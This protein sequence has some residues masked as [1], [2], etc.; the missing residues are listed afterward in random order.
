MVSTNR[1]GKSWYAVRAGEGIEL[2]E[3]GVFR[4][5]EE[6]RS[7]CLQDFRLLL[8]DEIRDLANGRLVFADIE[9]PLRVR[10]AFECATILGL[11]TQAT[12]WNA[13]LDLLAGRCEKNGRLDES[14]RSDAELAE[15]ADKCRAS[16]SPALLRDLSLEQLEAVGSRFAVSQGLS[17]SEAAKV[18][19]KMCDVKEKES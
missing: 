1:V 3:I 7:A 14:S 8:R 4:N 11:K 13:A 16:L 5:E 10:L 2:I 12:N 18:G 17:I 9:P 19:A 15:I 6:A